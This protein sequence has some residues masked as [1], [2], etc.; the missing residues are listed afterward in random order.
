V[1]DQLRDFL[2]HGNITNSVNFPNAQLSRESPFRLGIAHANVPNMLAQISSSLGGSDVNIHNML[3][4]SKGEMA[5]TLVDID[6]S[7]SEK[8]IGKIAAI[9][10]VLSV[11]SITLETA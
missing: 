4:K 2:E 7:V 8:V 1:V 5:Y 10:G 11:R 9:K 3:N 6:S